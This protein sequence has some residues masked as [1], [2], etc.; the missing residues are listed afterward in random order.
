M[1]EGNEEYWHCVCQVSDLA[2]NEIKKYQVDS[3]SILVTRTGDDFRIIPPFCPHMEEPLDESG[4]CSHG[5]ITCSKHL[6]EWDILTGT[7][8]GAAEKPLL[9]YKSEV[10]ENEVWV[11]MEK[12][13]VYEF[14]EEDDDD[15][16]F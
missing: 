15:F 5:V 9:L 3:I 10:R 4:M 11:Y 13:L 2:D 6:W 14:E 12:E 8:Q 16:E 7:E 1:S